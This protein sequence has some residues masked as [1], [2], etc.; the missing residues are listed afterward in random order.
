MAHFPYPALGVKTRVE[1]WDNALSQGKSAGRNM[2]G[3]R[4][5][6]THMP[7][8]YSD[9]FDF[10]YEA[11][12]EVDTRLE[13]FADWKNENQTGVIYYLKDGMVRGVMLCNVWEKVDAAR[14]LIS[15]KVRMTPAQLTGAI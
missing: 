5:A 15:S 3:A 6:Y 14:T 8:F 13:A 11:V 10:G 9:L 1:H 7:F 4:E 12:G 2:A